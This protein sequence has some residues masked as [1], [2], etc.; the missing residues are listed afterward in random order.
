MKIYHTLFW[1][2]FFMQIGSVFS[3]EI[4]KNLAVES[5]APD[6]FNVTHSF[7]WPSN[8]LVAIMENKDVLLIDVPYTPEATDSLLNWIFRK[9]GK[10]NIVAI[11]THFHVDRLGGNASLV[12]HKIPIHSSELTVDAIKNRGEQS[13]N[14]LISWISAESIK[15]Y[16]KNFNYVAPTSIFDSKKGLTLHFGKE[17]VYVKF[18]GIGHSV[19]NLIV[20]LPD[21]KAIFGGCMVLSMEADKEGNI[22]DGNK[23]EW[24][25]T[26]Q[27]IDTNGYNLVIPGHGKYGGID[28]IK[29]TISILNK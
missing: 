16:Y 27:S 21:K 26:I 29:Y 22:S 8:S 14:L 1:G 25:K 23:E 5:I 6:M 7:P 28:L 10:R 19:D 12:K 24:L 18:P 11:N 3:E 20:Y 9:Y 4:S 2:L 17:M 15:N 13:L